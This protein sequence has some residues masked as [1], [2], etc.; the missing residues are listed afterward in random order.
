MGEG[1]KKMMTEIVD[2]PL[3]VNRLSVPDSKAAVRAK[4]INNNT[5]LFSPVGVQVIPKM[6]IIL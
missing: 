1:K 3:P 6:A 5:G 2:V 4:K